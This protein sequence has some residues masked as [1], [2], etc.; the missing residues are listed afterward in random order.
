VSTG[1]L[2]AQTPDPL[3]AV[4]SHL[5]ETQIAGADAGAYR[6]PTGG[7]PQDYVLEQ[8]PSQVVSQRQTIR[9]L[10][11]DGTHLFGVTSH[12]DLIESD[13][14]HTWISDLP[15]G[16]VDLRAIHG[17]PNFLLVAGGDGGVFTGTNT[18]DIAFTRTGSSSNFNGAFAV[19]STSAWVVGDQGAA[20]QLKGTAW[21][22]VP[23]PTAFDLLGVTATPDGGLFAVGRHGT[24]LFRP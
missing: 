11:S 3:F 23:A 22:S 17:A 13:N 18:M 15:L 21:A 5:S 6:I 7:L 4:T 8:L 12:G 9:G 16:V 2:V 14:G 10:Y 1:F 20:L 24:V 19:S